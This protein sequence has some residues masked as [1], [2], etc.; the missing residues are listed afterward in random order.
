MKKMLAAVAAALMLCCTPVRAAETGIVSR[1]YNDGELSVFLRLDDEDMNITDVTA[2][3]KKTDVLEFRTLNETDLIRTTVLADR[4]VL[5]G[6]SSEV[7]S[8]VLREILSASGEN[9]TFRLL[10]FGS[11]G[12]S[13]HSDMTANQMRIL[14]CA[15]KIQPEDGP[16][17]LYEALK[18]FQEN[19]SEMQYGV[20]ERLIVFTGSETVNAADKSAADSVPDNVPVY[21]VLTDGDAVFDYNITSLDCST[22]YCAVPHESDFSR[23]ADM[24]AG[25]SDVYFLKTKLSAETVGNGGEKRIGI[26]LENSGKSIAFEET[27]DTGDQRYSAAEKSVNSL[28]LIVVIVT[29]IAAALAAVLVIILRKRKTDSISHVPVRS[30]EVSCHTM[31]LEKKNAARG[32]IFSSVS[33]RILFRD[34]SRQKIVLTGTENPEYVIEFTSE[35]ETV[36]GRN[37]SMSDV[38]IYNERSVSQRHCRVFSRNSKIY[39]EDLGSLN[40]TYVD[41]EE[42]TGETEIFSGSVLKI[43]RVSFDV[44]IIPLI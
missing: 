33:T 26:C 21:F 13:T 4:S 39:V 20:Y 3:G 35:K 8:G 25:I 23:A 40:H 14:D 38:M 43:G 16:S 29:L 1:Y 2:D 44:K 19:F 27:V 30:E 17:D 34:T 6:E 12:V 15:E 28:K 36:I 7:F 22:G 18:G 41:G 24:A 32:T 10:S 37:Q 42:V 31:P 5:S 9:E 11:G